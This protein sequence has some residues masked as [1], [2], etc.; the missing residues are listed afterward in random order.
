MLVLSSEDVEALLVGL[1]R[2][3]ESDF[4]SVHH[5]GTLHEVEHDVLQR[6]H[7]GLLVDQVNVDLFLGSDLDTY[8]ALD[9]I[10]ESSK[11]LDCVI[12]LPFSGHL[13]SQ[14][15]FN[16]LNLEEEDVARASCD[17]GLVINQVLLTNLHIRHLVHGPLAAVISIHDEGLA[18]SIERITLIF[19]RIVE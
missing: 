14:G 11:I 18:L 16:V 2:D 8:I 6:R 9:I 5:L 12:L 10:D 3:A 1:V 4:R 17:K 7:Q 19:V 15:V 13:P